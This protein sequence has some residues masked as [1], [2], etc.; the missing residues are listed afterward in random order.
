MTTNAQMNTALGTN[1]SQLVKVGAYLDRVS[2]KVDGNGDPRLNDVNDFAAHI[3][4]HYGALIRADL[5]QQQSGPDW[6]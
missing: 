1:N 3:Y 4:A 5:K 6:D 2:P